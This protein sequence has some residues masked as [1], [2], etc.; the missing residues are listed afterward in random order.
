M[1][2][3]KIGKFIA[4]LA[5]REMLDAGATRRKARRDQQNRFPLGEW[6]LYA[7]C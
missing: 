3:M 4:A 6:K 1:D 2:Q 7:R 5:E